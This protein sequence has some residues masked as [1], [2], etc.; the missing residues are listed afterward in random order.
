MRYLLS[1]S[2]ILLFSCSS[3]KKKGKSDS[4]NPLAGTSW[5]LSRIP[6][7][8][9]EETRKPVTL[10]FA[11]TTDRMGGHAGCNG[12]GGHY[13]VK[14]STLAVSK[15]MSTKM[16]CIPGMETENKV[17]RALAETDHFNISGDK[18][19]LMKAET[20]VAEFNRSKK[21]KK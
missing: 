17:L 21:G 19:T 15:V 2:V 7:F 18:L 8:Q 16:A 4:G 5:T 9:M 11:D 20:V 13:A 14:G 3:M 10:S 6:D 1:L 12:Y